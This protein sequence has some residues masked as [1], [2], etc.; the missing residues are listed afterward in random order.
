MKIIIN[1]LVL[2]LALLL[3][4][5]ST[6][7]SFKVGGIYYY[8]DRLG[9]NQVGVT[10]ADSNWDTAD[11][12]GDVNIPET[13]TYNGTTYSVTTIDE[14]AFYKCSGLTSITIPNSITTIGGRAFDYCNGLTRVNITDLK[15]WCH[16]Q[17]S[18]NL[19][20]P[21]YYANHLYQNGLEV[22]DLMIPNTVTTI[23]DYAFECCF[24]L[25][26]VNIP[27]SVTSIGSNAFQNC[28]GLTSVTIPDSVT[29]IGENAFSACS[30]LTNVIV[31]SWNP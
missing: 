26:S 8:Y 11:Y 16:I 25:A 9:E 6:A 31:E 29:F 28:S 14:G 15:A 27:N 10:D 22:T 1:F 18:D 17:F 30:G 12:S 13:V 19:S 20:N 23:G 21:L 3:P 5:T 4:A 2:L 7:Y 24:N